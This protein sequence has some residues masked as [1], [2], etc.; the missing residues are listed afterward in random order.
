MSGF[1]GAPSHRT[2]SHMQVDPYTG[3]PLGQPVHHGPMRHQD[4][5]PRTV[6]STGVVPGQSRRLAHLMSEQKRRE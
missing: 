1:G 2:H 3:R 5:D 6:G 4:P